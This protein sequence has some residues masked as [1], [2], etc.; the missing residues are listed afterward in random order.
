MDWKKVRHEV[1]SCIAATR[2]ILDCKDEFER[3]ELNPLSVARDVCSII[4]DRIRPSSL[5]HSGPYSV[6]KLFHD[7]LSSDLDIDRMDYLLRDSHM[8]GVNYGLYDPDRIL[9]S[10][11]AYAETHTAELRTC[12]RYSGLGAL[13][14]LLM[15]RYQ[16]HAQIYGHKTNRA[17]NAMLGR[18]RERLL[19]VG[20]KWY[21]HCVTIEHLLKA[22]VELDDRAFVNELLDP[23]LDNGLG[24]IGEIASKLFVE[25]KIVKRVFEER[26]GGLDKARTETAKARWSEH[27]KQLEKEGIWNA[28]DIFENKGPKIN[29]PNYHLKVIRKHP[30]EGWYQVEELLDHSCVAQFLPEL[31]CTFRLFCK[32]T[33]VARAKQLLPH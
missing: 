28:E 25:R 18:I 8:C 24:K 21:R 29:T 33:Q 14:D 26:A 13:E 23:A 6:Q 1:I 9:K 2:I 30:T 22:F 32:E 7:I 17:C 12:I 16:M 31:E 3:I 4:D 27:K 10:M 20:W 19:V 11:C 15:S 5:M